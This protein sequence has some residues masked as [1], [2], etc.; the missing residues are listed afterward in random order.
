[1][2]TVLA[3]L[4]VVIGLFV[5]VRY[6]ERHSIFFPMREILDDPSL[7]GMPFEDVYFKTLDGVE[8]NAW[9]VPSREAGSASERSVLLFFH[10]NAGN[11]SHRIEKIDFF[12][13]LG[14]DVFIID[15]RGY[16]RS[17]G[18]P[19]EKGV[20]RDARTAYLHLVSQR[21]KQAQQVI[22]YGE[23]IGGAMAVDVAHRERVGALIVED[24]FTSIQ[25]L[26]RVIYP[27]I[28]PWLVRTRMDSL[29]KIKEL[30]CPKL[31]I[32]SVD[33]EIIP[34][35]LGEKLFKEA[36]EPKVFLKVRGGHNTSF[37]ESQS[38]LEAGI[39]DFLDGL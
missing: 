18:F 34:F 14:V 33:D 16:G 19:S 31:V 7:H 29:S 1:M 10:G 4:V 28:P 24:T 13:R 5:L 12:N 26:V 15:Y 21:G 32:H 22:V 25:D 36:A 17:S 30:S 6:V 8:L 23:S 27:F 37:F 35:A 11:I 9:Y 20:M 2:K 39:R 38:V 3:L